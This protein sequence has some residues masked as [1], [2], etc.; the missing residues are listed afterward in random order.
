MH[1]FDP[2]RGEENVRKLVRRRAREEGGTHEEDFDKVFA[3]DL[4]VHVRF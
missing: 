3:V 4:T 2:R 1:A